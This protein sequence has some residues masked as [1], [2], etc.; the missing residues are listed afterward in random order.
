MEQLNSMVQRH[1]VIRNSEAGQAFALAWK[2]REQALTEARA[3]LGDENATLS[4]QQVAPIKDWLTE[5]VFE[6]EQ[7]YPD[8]ILLGAKFR[9][10]WD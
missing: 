3:A 5:R 10:E 9:R 2:L 7:R 1:Q 8:F 4:G 6:L